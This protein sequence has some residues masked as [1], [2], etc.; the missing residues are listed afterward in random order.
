M[1]IKRIAT[2]GAILVLTATLAACGDS[3]NKI[4]TQLSADP[5]PSATANPTDAPLPTDDA[6][7]EGARGYDAALGVDWRSDLNENFS[8][9]ALDNLVADA[10]EITYLF[11]NGE[12][13]DLFKPRTVE[14]SVFALEAVRPY[15]STEMYDYL[16]E[17]EKSTDSAFSQTSFSLIPRTEQDGAFLLGADRY[18]TSGV[19]LPL[20]IVPISDIVIDTYTQDGTTYANYVRDVRY[21]ATTTTVEIT[22]DARLEYRLLPDGNNHWI[23]YGVNNRVIADPVVVSK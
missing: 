19:V 8:Q 6:A 3:S 12:L 14:E 9:E 20:Q 1:N 7:L 21:T 13:S 16:V 22:Y 18:D 23:L 4:A 2:Y 5:S 17:A 15:V 10:R 11:N